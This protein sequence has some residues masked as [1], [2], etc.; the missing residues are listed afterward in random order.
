M[1]NHM[2][3]LG[4]SRVR[5]FT[6]ALAAASAVLVVTGLTIR[7]SEAQPS[8]LTR[9]GSAV[10]P[11]AAA[12]VR[13]ER[14]IHTFPHKTHD[15]QAFETRFDG[16]NFHAVTAGGTPLKDGDYKLDNGGAIK[17]RGGLVV[18][19]AFGAVDA[20]KRTGIAKGISPDG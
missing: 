17:V 19:D 7:S 5:R 20:F 3:H 2:S 14:V 12:R 13:M 18:W 8:A 10:Q 6:V 15:G 1:E 9:Q 4:H 11:G 16:K